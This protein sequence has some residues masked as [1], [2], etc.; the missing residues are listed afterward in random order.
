PTIAIAVMWLLP[1]H[2]FGELL[3]E[4]RGGLAGSVGQHRRVQS[5]VRKVGPHVTLV[6]LHHVRAFLEAERKRHRATAGQ[7]ASD[8]GVL[9]ATE[10]A[11]DRME[12]AT[13]VSL[14]RRKVKGKPRLAPFE[15][16][17]HVSVSLGRV[18]PLVDVNDRVLEHPSPLTAECHLYGL[19]NLM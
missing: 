10:T 6:R 9:A 15:E 3:R 14:G 18:A 13:L 19:Q 11:L 2:L 4:E 1:V 16:A 5:D 7:P 17:M 12:E 8:D